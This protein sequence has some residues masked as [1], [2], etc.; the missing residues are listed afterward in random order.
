MKKYFII[1]SIVVS[2]I[3]INSILQY[4]SKP[5]VILPDNPVVSVTPT[6]DPVEI[7]KLKIE[8]PNNEKPKIVVTVP[9]P[10]PVLGKKITPHV[11]VSDKGNTYVAYTEKIDLGFKFQPKVVAGYSNDI[12][13]GVGATIFKFWRLETDIILFY[14]L[15]NDFRL[16][17]GESYQLTQ[18]TSIGFSI[19][20]NINLE[21]TVGIYL[22]LKF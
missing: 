12:C 20:E 4:C 3:V 5:K 9:T 15:N 11:V 21:P 2:L 6:V 19:S 10:V 18:N 13:L 22:S 17:I 16:G 8:L 1:G 14:E 7:D